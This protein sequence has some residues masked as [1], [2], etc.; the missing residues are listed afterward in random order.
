MVDVR[1]A[2]KRLSV[3]LR[4]REDNLASAEELAARYIKEFE[5]V[6]AEVVGR[7]S[8]R[9]PSPSPAL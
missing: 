7:L 6:W 8:A 3:H 5:E 4:I 2:D 1:L 9:G